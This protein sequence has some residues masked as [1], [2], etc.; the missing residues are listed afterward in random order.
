MGDAFLIRE[1]KPERRSIMRRHGG[2]DMSAQL[3]IQLLVLIV[4][5][6]ALVNK[7]EK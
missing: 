3:L 7:A 2:K 5:I 4:M 6:I 1:E